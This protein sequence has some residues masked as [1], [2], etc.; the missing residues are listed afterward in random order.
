MERGG[1][2]E[3]RGGVRRGGRRTGGG[4]GGEGGGE[5]KRRVKTSGGKERRD[6]RELTE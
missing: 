3:G 1:V 5:W 2:E 6:A 4:R